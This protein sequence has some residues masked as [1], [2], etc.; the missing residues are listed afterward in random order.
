MWTVLSVVLGIAY[1]GF[2]ERFRYFN[3]TDLYA[4]VFEIGIFEGKTLDESRVSSYN[5]VVIRKNDDED[6][7]LYLKITASQGRWKPDMS[8]IYLNI[9]S[10]LQC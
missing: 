2:K 3:D 1:E 6:S 10:E 4:S 8:R 9:T 5:K 7:R